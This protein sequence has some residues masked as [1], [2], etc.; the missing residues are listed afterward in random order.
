MT[1]S[2]LTLDE[3]L[4]ATKVK[5]GAKGGAIT[6]TLVR[7]TDWRPDQ[8]AILFACYMAG[9][10]TILEAGEGVEPKPSYVLHADPTPTWEAP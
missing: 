8:L 3:V 2:T 1:T 5:V 10:V 7:R 4:N 9:E 6:E